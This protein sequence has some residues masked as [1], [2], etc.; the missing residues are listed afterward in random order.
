M[1][2]NKILE[3]LKREARYAQRSFSSRLLYQTYGKACMAWELD[4]ITKTEF[5]EIN[6]MTVVFM[7]TDKEFIKHCY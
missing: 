2:N 5:M 3:Q 6:Q 7:N 4:A 1:K